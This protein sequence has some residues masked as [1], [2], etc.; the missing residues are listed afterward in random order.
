MSSIFG[1]LPVSP[2]NFCCHLL[3]SPTVQMTKAEEL[4][5]KAVGGAGPSGGD[6]SHSGAN[7]NTSGS[8]GEQQGPAA[9]GASGGTTDGGAGGSMGSKW[10]LPFSSRKSSSEPGK[11]AIPGTDGLRGSGSPKHPPSPKGTAG[12]A[13]QAGSGGLGQGM[14]EAPGLMD[15]GGSVGA[16]GGL[17]RPG[18][19]VLFTVVVV[20]VE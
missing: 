14:E 13:S 1:P 6:S 19:C 5:A 15:S 4:Q 3:L 11:S 8:G 18:W 16:V 20:V 17:W 12:D 10:A 2:T 9:G 7:P